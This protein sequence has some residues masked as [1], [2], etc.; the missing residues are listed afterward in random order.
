MADDGLNEYE[1]LRQENIRHN[2]VKLG[3]LRRKAD[4]LSAAIRA[5]KPK[6]AYQRRERPKTPTVPV[7]SS[8]RFRGNLPPDLHSTRLSSSLA[9]SILGAPPPE[10]ARIRATDDFNAARDMVLKP[11]HVRKVVPSSILSLRVLPL[12]DRTVVAAGDRLGNIVFWDVDG[13]SE[14]QEGDGADR[15]FCYWPHT[16]PVSAI[17]AHQAAPHKIYSSSRQ[18]EICLMDFE[19][20][21]FSMVHLWEWPI[22]SLCQAQ[23]SIRCLYFGDG[24][25]GLTLFD[26]RVGKVLTTW[27]AHD[28]RISSID[29]HP[30]KTHMLATSSRDRTACVWDVRNMKRK[31][32]DSLKV[33]KFQKSAHSAYFSPTGRMLAVTSSDHCGT[34]QVFSVDDFEKAHTVDYNNQIGSWPTKFKVI[35]GWNDI[36]LYVGNMSKGIDIISADV[37]DSGLS[38]LKLN[39][40]C[41]RSD[42]ITPVPYEICAHPYK[43]GYLA[44]SSSHSGKVFLWTRA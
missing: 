25:G 31:E 16:G 24:N 10:E 19:K 14:G 3:S 21:N 6:R 29:F 35:W 28:E 12:V 7:R 11:A 1:R 2:E 23:N 17:V 33:F 43:V 36:D 30:E 26:E 44:C 42:P 40:T 15:V 27:D 38:A 4:E 39:N 37:N 22:H 34:V 20:E 9:S 32:P 41:L 18:G 8:L 13:V 5:A